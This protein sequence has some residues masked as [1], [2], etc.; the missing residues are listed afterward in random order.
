[1]I[2]RAKEKGVK[3]GRK[4]KLS[5]EEI[6]EIKN[7]KKDGTLISRIMLRYNISK[8]TVYRALKSKS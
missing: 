3:F 1:M 7:L 5:I 8:S 2:K 6:I 4:L